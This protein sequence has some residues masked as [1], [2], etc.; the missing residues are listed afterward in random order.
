MQV[1]TQVAA[2]ASNASTTPGTLVNL[3]GGQLGDLVVSELNGRYYEQTYRKNKF[4]WANPSAVTPAA[5]L[6]G[7]APTTALYNPPGSTVNLVLIKVSAVFAAAPGVAVAIGLVAGFN[8][9]IPTGITNG[10]PVNNFIGGAVGQG[11]TA[12][13]ITLGTAPAQI[14][15]L[16]AVDAVGAIS[17]PSVFVDVGGSIVIPPGGYVAINATAACSI[18]GGFEWDEVP[19]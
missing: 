10:A 17:P 7:T 16:L 4:S 14:L 18:M 2:G 5:T 9:A 1:Q 19:V 13:V 15:P 3:R 12:T 8:A 6:A 11:K